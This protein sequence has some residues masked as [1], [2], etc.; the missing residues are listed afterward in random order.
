VAFGLLATLIV[1]PLAWLAE[2]PTVRPLIGA[3]GA[4]AVGL[5]VGFAVALM[6]LIGI[7]SSPGRIVL[8]TRRKGALKARLTVG[9]AYGGFVGVVVWASTGAAFGFLIGLKAGAIAVPASGL[10][11]SLQ[12]V[13]RRF[14]PPRDAS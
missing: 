14:R 8:K 5:A 7:P 2:P 6:S 12:A 9:L 1:W 4:L 13:P 3:V 10:V 11:A